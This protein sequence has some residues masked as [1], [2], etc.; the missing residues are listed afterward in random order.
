VQA[1]VLERQWALKRER[2]R[3]QELRRS[4]M[5]T[6]RALS[7]AVEARDDGGLEGAQGAIEAKR[8]KRTAPGARM[9]PGAAQTRAGR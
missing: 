8:S 5:A 1:R 2:A 7:N 6:V 3:S 4:Y 9:C